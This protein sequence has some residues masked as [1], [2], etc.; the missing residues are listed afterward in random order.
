MSPNK[1]KNYGKIETRRQ[2]LRRCGRI[3]KGTTEEDALPPSAAAQGLWQ[4]IQ[5][6]RRNFGFTGWTKV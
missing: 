2:V 5:S 6:W 1:Q 3:C 4:K